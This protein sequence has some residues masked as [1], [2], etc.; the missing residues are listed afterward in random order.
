MACL[1]D[2]TKTQNIL[3][4]QLFSIFLDYVD[5]IENINE[6]KDATTLTDTS[7][8]YLAK[9]SQLAKSHD[10]IKLSQN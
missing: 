4:I 3:F 7:Q 6:H 2:Y 8:S 9:P 5:K 10:T 1:K